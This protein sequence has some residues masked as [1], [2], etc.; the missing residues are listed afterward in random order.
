VNLPTRT[1]N[2]RNRPVRLAVSIVLVLVVSLVAVMA[3]RPSAANTE[4]WTPLLGKTAPGIA[5]STLAGAPFTLSSLRGGYVVL[6]FFASW[7]GPCQL[8][9][10]QL[11]V[12][13]RRHEMGGSSSSSRAGA[14]ARVVGVAFE[15][16][17]ASALG[18]DSQYG[19]T[20]PALEDP[21]AR[22]ALEYGVR[23]PPETFLISPGGVVLAHVDG[24]VTASFLDRL[25]ADAAGR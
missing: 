19:A 1:A 3:T 11:V 6:N 16:S 8:E 2:L 4:A 23:G 9:E 20:W 5:G 24:Q 18:F 7:C 13:A 12:F 21:G 17:A 15:D 10:P 22:I 25:I 14:T